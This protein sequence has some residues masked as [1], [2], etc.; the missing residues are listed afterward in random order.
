M[1]RPRDTQRSK[2]YAAEG[3]VAKFRS[4]HADRL[5]TTTKVYGDFGKA[6]RV[7]ISAAQAYVDDLLAQRW[8]QSRWG[9]RRIEVGSK[10]YGR[11]VGYSGGPIFLPPWARTEH[12]ILHEVAHTLLTSR[13]AAH[14]PEFAA[15]FLTLVEHRCG[16]EAA[17]ALR[18]SFA[19]H[20]VK[21]RKGLAVV[22]KAGQRTV[23][24]K[25]AALAAAKRQTKAE[26]TLLTGSTRR[27]QAAA[28][29]RASVK[30]GHFGP[31][32]SKP[33]THALATAR[34]LEAHRP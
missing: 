3:V 11:A 8:F 2:V 25:T 7:M 21:Y 19:E 15:T 1:P 26:Q 17:K 10:S 12:T 13:H 30:A 28:V 32:G 29:I 31:S 16:V 34:Q 6:D 18:E 27:A 14:G 4:P 33:R 9:Q 24:T 23:V 20:R 22:P 5:L